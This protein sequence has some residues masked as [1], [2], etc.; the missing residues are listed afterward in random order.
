MWSVPTHVSWRL[1]NIYHVGTMQHPSGAKFEVSSSATN[2]VCNYTLAIIIIDNNYRVCLWTMSI[3]AK[4]YT[5]GLMALHTQENSH[6]TSK[7]LCKVLYLYFLWGIIIMKHF[8][9]VLYSDSRVR[10]SLLTALVMSG[11]DTLLRKLLAI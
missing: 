5:H 8:F 4:G 7:L 11:L 6:I 9:L 10:G 3:M 1:C 2:N